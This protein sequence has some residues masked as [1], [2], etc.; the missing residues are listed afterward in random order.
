MNLKQNAINRN[1][2]LSREIEYLKKKGA[3]GILLHTYIYW[4]HTDAMITDAV[5]KD[6]G[7][8]DA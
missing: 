2:L 6:A 7:K 1:R 4:I 3:E 5:I 8:K